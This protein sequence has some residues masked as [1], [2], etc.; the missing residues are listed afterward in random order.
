MKKPGRLRDKMMMRFRNVML[1]LTIMTGFLLMNPT[2]VAAEE[3]P[4]LPSVFYGTVQ[5]NGENVETGTIISVKMDGAVVAST[6]VQLDG[7]GNTV[8][9]MNVPGSEDIEGDA[10]NFFIGSLQADHDPAA[11]RSGTIN[12]VDVSI[13]TETNEA[14]VAVADSFETMKNKQLLLPGNELTDNDTDA[15]GDSL[16]VVAVFNPQH[17]TV[18]LAGGTITFT[19]AAGFVGVAGF[20]YRVSDGALTDTTHV[21]IDVVEKVFIPLFFK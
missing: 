16:S 9:S 17:G 13:T 19:P 2:W 5:E 12:V 8:Y 11:W 18:Q 10:V 15:D 20:D 14:P 6:T 1:I 4:A 3:P 7:D 21:T